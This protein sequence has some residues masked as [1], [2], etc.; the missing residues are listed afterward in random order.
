MDGRWHHND[1]RKTLPLSI[2]ITTTSSSLC[3]SSTPNNVPEITPHQLISPHQTQISAGEIFTHLPFKPQKQ[4]LLPKIL[5]SLHCNK[6]EPRLLFRHK[7]NLWRAPLQETKPQDLPRITVPTARENDARIFQREFRFK[8]D[9]GVRN[10]YLRILLKPKRHF[11]TVV[12]SHR[13]G[14]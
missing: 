9:F 5:H 1:P 2:S 7:R 4:S 3:I 13:R 12:I 11:P 8:P 10:V 14:R 6:F